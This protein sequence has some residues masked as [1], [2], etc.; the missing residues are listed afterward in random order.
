VGRGAVAY[1]SAGG[2][3]LAL[4][5]VLAK[6]YVAAAFHEVE[7][8][9]EGSVVMFDDDDVVIK[10]VAIVGDVNFRD[11]SAAGCDDI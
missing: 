10:A 4:G 1:V 11:D 5:D 7:I 2:D 6:L 8:T 9:C 3:A